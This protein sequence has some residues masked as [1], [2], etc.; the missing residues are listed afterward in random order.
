MEGLIRDH[1][2]AELIREIADARMSGALRLSR[3]PAKIV[4]Y[5]ESGEPVFA[6]SN[7]RAHRLREAIKRNGLINFAGQTTSD[8]DLA[9]DL[10]ARK[11]LTPQALQET[12]DALAGDILRTA[13]LWTNGDWSF[14]TRVRVGGEARTQVD[15]RQLLLE[16][17][18]H[19]PIDF[20]RRFATEDAAYTVIGIDHSF[21]LAP[22]EEA[23]WARAKTAGGAVSLTDLTANGLSREVVTRAVFGLT[24]AGLLESSESKNLLGSGTRP[25]PKSVAAPPRPVAPPAERDSESAVDVNDFIERVSTAKDHYEV[26][27]VPP[28]ATAENIKDSYHQLARW[29]HPDRFHQSKKDLRDRID[30]A[31]ARVAQ[32]YETLGDDSRRADY[33]RKLAGKKSASDQKST[34]EPAAKAAKDRAETVFRQGMDALRRNQHDEAIRLLGE[35]ASLEPRRARYR[36]FYG[37]AMSHQPNL[38]RN[39]EAELQAAVTMEPNNSSFHL[40]LAELYQTVGLRSRAQNEAARAL[41]AD[42]SS[43][44]ARIL[45]S[46]LKK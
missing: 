29:F 39:A 32:A 17:A 28:A 38:R 3:E 23:L 2:L 43:E 35:A 22:A 36:A 33:D 11:I 12:R 10:I 5:F 16:S 41:A 27:D 13:L 30:S 34:S 21:K 19:L 6:A 1:P 20:L 18:R 25:K 9:A 4:V 37:S 40:M 45:L 24:V 7:L 15:I 46:K 44:A 14:D 31:F 8:E 26:L 42:P